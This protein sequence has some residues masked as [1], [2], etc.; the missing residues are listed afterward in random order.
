MDNIVNSG[1]VGNTYMIKIP[2]T[3]S[4]IADANKNNSPDFFVNDT[5]VVCQNSFFSYPF[6]ATDMDGDSL[7]YS[8]CSAFLGG[9]PPPNGNAEPNPAANPPYST[10]PYKNPFNSGAPMGFRVK[11][12]GATGLISGIAPPISIT[13]EYVLTVCVTEYRN[14]VAFAESRKELHIRVR[15]CD[16]IKAFLNPRPVTCDGFTLNFSNE[17]ATPSGTEFVWNFGDPASGINN[18]STSPT[19]TH[20]YVDTGI[21]TL[22]LKVSIGGLC[23]DSTTLPI[24]VYPGFFPDFTTTSPLCK[25][26]PVQFKDL[27]TTNYGTVTGWRWNFGNT[28]ALNDTSRLQDP[29]YAY[30]QPGIYRNVALIVG[31]TFGCVD[32]VYRDIAIADNPALTVFPKDTVYCGLDDVKLMAMGTGNFSWLP[33][34]NIINGNTASPTVSPTVP[35]TYFVI[36]NNNGCISR[37]SAK[38]SPVNDLTASITSTINAICEEDTVTLNGSSNHLPVIWQWAPAQ[39]VLTP[40]SQTTKAFPSTNTNYTLTVQWGTN[41]IATAAK[42]ITVTPLA[43]PDA[44]TDKSICVGQTSAQLNA[45]GG[46]NYQWTPA[47]DLNNPSIANPVARPTVTTQYIVSVGVNGCNKRRNDTV[48]VLVRQLPPLQITNDTLICSIDT[49]KLTATGNG[50]LAWSPNYMINDL[51]SFTPLVS[52]DNPTKYYTTLTD[53]FGCKKND[54]VFVDVRPFITVDAGKDTTICKTDAITLQPISEALQYKWTPAI[55]I[56][57]NLLKTPLVNPASTT[58]YTVTANLG[59]CQDMDDVIVKVVPYPAKQPAKDTTVCF[60]MNAQLYASGGSIYNWTPA[61]FLNSTDIAT[62]LAINPTQDV[63]YIATVTDT[64]GCPKPVYDTFMVRVTQKVNVDAGPRDTSI[65]LGEPLFLQA[66]GAQLYSWTPVTGLDKPNNSNPTASI[67]NNTEYVVL[68]K[69][70][71]GCKDT[72]TIAVKVYKVD[73]DLYVPTAF[74]PNGDGMND[75]FRPILLGMRKL[76]F[77]NVYN[78]WGQLVYSTKQIS[79]TNGWDGN[80]LGKPQDPGTFVWKAEGVSYQG[81]ISS[82]KGYVVLIR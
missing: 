62:P 30:P 39:T 79:H 19:P 69:T 65:V 76:N 45:T 16:P 18:T 35:T 47:A 32:T 33:N 43:N 54:S 20:T 80:H 24:K 63:Q 36:L 49:L 31:N 15:D 56:N 51:N 37:D 42:T 1:D 78:R 3:N 64:L 68:G 38:I 13:G 10:V 60:E 48:N 2:G 23:A 52:P 67:E 58:T 14:G 61:T 50:S 59:K 55:N 4:P 77:F 25:G 75:V 82:K 21:Y 53:G 40:N 27:T 26:Q 6:R 28:A 5:I 81:K 70:I 74:S 66:T 71:D 11:I 34:S 17:V 72:D 41:C 8:L 57:N 9:A 29:T 46:D 73:P 44:G 12:D 22:K 7:S